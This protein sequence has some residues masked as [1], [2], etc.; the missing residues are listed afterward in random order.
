MQCKCSVQQSYVFGKNTGFSSHGCL[1]LKNKIIMTAHGI[2][3]KLLS[4]Y[5]TFQCPGKSSISLISQ[6]VHDYSFQFILPPYCIESALMGS[7]LSALQ[8][9]GF[10]VF[11]V[12]LMLIQRYYFQRK[13]N[14]DII[15]CASKLKNIVSSRR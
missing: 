12:H 2:A 10:R 9:L 7:F 6:Q 1:Y 11:L 8:T 3:C 14:V 13:A 4:S 5:S 15:F